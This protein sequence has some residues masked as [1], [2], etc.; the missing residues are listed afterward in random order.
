[1][2][3]ISASHFSL[4]RARRELEKA[5]DCEDWEAV[6][7]WDQDLGV[8]L[9]RAFDD[10]DRDTRALVGELEKVLSLYATIVSSMPEKA[11]HA[12]MGLE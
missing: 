12:G 10:E 11:I 8:M 5:Y 1:M 6:R 9:N 4:V 7:Q 2:S 3:V